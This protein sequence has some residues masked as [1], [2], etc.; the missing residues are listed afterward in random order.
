MH[1]LL[2][3]VSLLFTIVV[4]VQNQEY[5]E[6]PE[7]YPNLPGEGDGESSP[8][9]ISGSKIR[10]KRPNKTGRQ[11]SNSGKE[12]TTGLSLSLVLLVMLVSSNLLVCCGKK[13]TIH[14]NLIRN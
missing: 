1:V 2:I 3:L 14:I 13:V 6:H 4:C 12:F 10:E 11:T 8:K 9:M 7:R 5:K